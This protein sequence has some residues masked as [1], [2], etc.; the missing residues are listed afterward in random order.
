[1]YKRGEP[2]RST[3]TIEYSILDQKSRMGGFVYLSV[4][5]AGFGCTCMN[6]FC[7]MLNFIFLA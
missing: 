3:P 5:V 2:K 4:S 6:S 7:D 1:M